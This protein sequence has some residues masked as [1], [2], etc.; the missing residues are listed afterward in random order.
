LQ[1]ILNPEKPRTYS[2]RD[3]DEF[4]REKLFKAS[5]WK[6]EIMEYK[7]KMELGKAVR[8]RNMLNDTK[9]VSNDVIRQS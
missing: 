4:C 5:M 6:T 3:K 2:S 7:S 9:I 8:L 1:L